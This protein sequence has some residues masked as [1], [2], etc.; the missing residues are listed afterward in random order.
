[1]RSFTDISNVNPSEWDT[2]SS[3]V[4]CYRRQNIQQI[5]MDGQ[6]LYKYDVIAYTIEEYSALAPFLTAKQ[7]LEE[8]LNEIEQALE[9]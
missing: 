2:E 4:V 3:S 7:E 8:A 5:E 9:V 6:L 1:M